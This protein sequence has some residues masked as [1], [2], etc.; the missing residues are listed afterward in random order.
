[1]NTREILPLL[2]ELMENR[3]KHL[4]KRAID[5]PDEAF[6]QSDVDLLNIINASVLSGLFEPLA[7]EE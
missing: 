3:L 1:M 2:R 7:K 4:R 6:N 5:S